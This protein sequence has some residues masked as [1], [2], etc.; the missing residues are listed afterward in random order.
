METEVPD[1]C[2][3]V[4]LPPIFSAWW[5]SLETEVPDRCRLINLPPIFSAWRTSLETEVPDRCRLIN[6]PPI[7]SAWRTSLET[8]VPDR[9]RL[10]NLPPI[11]SA[12]RTSLETE[13][14]DR[15]WVINL[16]PIFSAW[17]T[18]LET[19]VP[20]RC[21]LVNLPPIFSAWRTSLETEVP[22]RCWLVN[23]PPIF[24][25][26]RTSL[27]TEVPDRCWL[28]NLPPIFSAWRTS[29]ETE[30]PDMVSTLSFR[31]PCLLRR[32]ITPSMS[33]SSSRDSIPVTLHLRPQPGT[34]LKSVVLPINSTARV[35]MTKSIR[36]STRKSAYRVLYLPLQTKQPN[37]RVCWDEMQVK[38]QCMYVDN[39]CPHRLTWLCANDLYTE[40][41]VTPSPKT[42]HSDAL[43]TDSP[44]TPFL[45]IVQWP[46]FYR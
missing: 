25:A 24:S 29:L 33:T 31:L 17:R 38:A 20:D 3:L 8:E 43:S 41:T 40:S 18:S 32:F 19:E 14:P 21:W 22:D 12:W 39:F 30:V 26:W 28:V 10:I 5:R 46:P 36:I 4:N 13:V 35:C 23:L 27:E 15:C 9:C 44:V 42:V 45:Q 37:T 34:A 11:F 6:L 1:R 2:W 16:P 7:F